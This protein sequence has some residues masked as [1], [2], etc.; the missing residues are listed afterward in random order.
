[1]AG[2][3]RTGPPPKPLEQKRKLG[4]PGARRLPR[5]SDTVALEP[6]AVPDVVLPTPGDRL[7]RELMAGPA[8]EWISGPDFL[9]VVAL[10]RDGWNERHDLMAAI[11]SLGDDWY[12]GRYTP[13]AVARLGVVERNL[14]LWLSQL[15]LTPADRSRLGVAEVRA[16]SRLEELQQKAQEARAARGG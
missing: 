9:G 12:G 11:A 8:G 1:M 14:T 6:A 7:V 15:G 3:R 16:K 2:L 13:A 10:L 4:N 5:P